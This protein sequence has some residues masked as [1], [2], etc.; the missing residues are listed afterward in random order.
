[1]DTDD[2]A[3]QRMNITANSR[4]DYDLMRYL[5]EF[6]SANNPFAQAYKMMYKVEQE[7]L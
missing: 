7:E 2:A 4:C 5:S 6:M 1:M 3:E